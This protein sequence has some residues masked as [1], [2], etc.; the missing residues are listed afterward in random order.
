MS[1]D[2]NN[3]MKYVI[4]SEGATV[5]VDGQLVTV[6]K[7]SSNFASLVQALLA[8]LWND[9]RNHLRI[10]TSIMKWA[11]GRFAIAG[12][13]ISFDGQSLPSE[14]NARILAMVAEGADPQP[15]FNFWER[16]QDNPSSRSVGQLWRFL[17]LI[18]VPL[19]SDGSFLAYKGVNVSLRDCYTDTIDNSPGQVVTI[20]RNRVSDDPNTPCHFGLHVGS[21]EYASGFGSRVVIC[22]VHPADVVCVPNDE[23]FQKMRVCRYEVVGLHGDGHMPSTTIDDGDWLVSSD[24]DGQG[25]D[26]DWQEG[27]TTADHY[28]TD[29]LDVFIEEREVEE[30]GFKSA[31]DVA[32]ARREAR[33]TPKWIRDIDAMTTAQELATVSMEVL[34]RYAS[35]HL[36]IVGASKIAG[37]KV[38]LIKAI[39]KARAFDTV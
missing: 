27:D 13:V 8:G 4:T 12:N 23:S 14:L 39:I 10:D 21:L 30:P 29:D 36:R 17:S 7:G 37:G 11:R 38:G 19:T 2:N 35:K 18:G 20:Q 34:R 16:L 24:N 22:K 9:A 26:G 28:S 3:G 32:L 1:T 5:V 33:R 15:L 31:V 6:N 25:D